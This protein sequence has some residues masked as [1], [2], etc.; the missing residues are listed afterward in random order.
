MQDS[1]HLTIIL[2]IQGE[3]KKRALVKNTKVIEKIVINYN[4]NISFNY[5]LGFPGK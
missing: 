5:Y 4:N 3:T 1:S 2:C